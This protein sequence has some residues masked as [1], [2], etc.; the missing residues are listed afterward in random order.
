MFKSLITKLCATS[1]GIVKNKGRINRYSDM[2]CVSLR[3][4]WIKMT[5]IKLSN[6]AL[7]IR[8]FLFLAISLFGFSGYSNADAQ[9]SQEVLEQI[10]QY[11]RNEYERKQQVEGYTID[12]MEKEPT[13]QTK[14]FQDTTS[15]SR[16]NLDILVRDADPN[17]I[18]L[19]VLEQQ[20][21]EALSNREYE[22]SIVLYY[23]VLEA[24]PKDPDLLTAV[25]IA[26]HRLGDYTEAQAYYNRALSLA[27]NHQVAL[28]NYLALVSET[29]PQD[30]ILEIT[31]LL[32]VR[33][34]DA[35][36]YALLASINAKNGNYDRAIDQYRISTEIEPK[37]FHYLYNLAV[38]LDKAGKLKQAKEA[39]FSIIKSIPETEID[40]I[41][42][43]KVK[44]RYG[45][46]KNLT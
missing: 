31:R 36:L 39:Y 13:R 16:L 14:Q 12:H 7:R 30:A 34:R 37:N 41:P 23:K 40:S 20:A 28:Y 1:G 42:Y 32:E 43:T 18:K 21:Y 3:F 19:N 25:A 8:F 26:Y 33:K 9:K 35:Y 29:D 10:Y 38:A 24:R 11:N 44:E 5:K 15:G 17:F 46:L 45:L 22:N 4:F 2:L 27:R 6:T